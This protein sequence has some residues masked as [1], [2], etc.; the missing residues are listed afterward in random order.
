MYRKIF[1]VFL[2]FYCFASICYA[3]QI[4][5]NYWQAK[6][7]FLTENK[8]KFE[9]EL[10]IGKED[11]SIEQF[12]RWTHFMEARID[13][14]TGE[15]FDAGMFWKEKQNY[16]NQKNNK[17]TRSSNS[18]WQ[19]L[20]PFSPFETNG[21]TRGRLGRINCITMHPTDAN[22]IF[23]GTP[24]GGIW[25]STNQGISWTSNTDRLDNISIA[26]IAIDPTNTNI[27]YAATG[28]GY[29][30][31][32]GGNF[33]GGTYSAGLIKSIDGGA[34]WNTTGLSYNLNNLRTIR[35]ILLYPDN[36][37]VIF[38]STSNGL[39]KSIDAGVT[40]M[41]VLSGSHYSVTFNPQ[42]AQTMYA[43]SGAVRKST[44]GGNTW[45]IITPTTTS[46]ATGDMRNYLAVS[47]QDSNILYYLFGKEDY[48]QLFKSTNGG[49]SW[50]DISADLLA[51][52]Y[53]S[54][55]Y[56]AAVMNIDPN[57]DN[58][59]M[60]GG[61]Y[62]YESKDGGQTFSEV[63]AG[64]LHADH[65]CITYSKSQNEVCYIGC[66]GGLYRK[67]NN[68]L[69]MRSEGLV[70]S[71]IYNVAINPKNPENFYMGLQDNGN[72]A[73]KKGNRIRCT[74]ADGMENIVDSRDTNHTYHEIQYGG[75]YESNDGGLNTNFMNNTAP[76]E[77][78]LPLTQ[79]Y[80]TPFSIYQGVNQGLINL[81]N[82]SKITIGTNNITIL[83]TN[84][85]QPKR[86][87]IS[88]GRRIWTSNSG[89]TGP[90]KEIT[91]TLNSVSLSLL[92]AAVSSNDTVTSYAVFG[93]FNATQKVFKT[94]NNGL[95]WT[96]ITDNLPNVPVNTIC[97]GHDS[98]ETVYIGTDLGVFFR[99]KYMATW[100]PF[101]KNLPNVIITDLR[102]SPSANLLY[103]ASY[104]RG[105]WRSPTQWKSGEAPLKT[106]EI[107]LDKTITIVPNPAKENV[108][109]STAE[110]MT[111]LQI[112]NSLGAVV[113][114][115]QP[116]QNNLTIQTS[117]FVSGMYVVLIKT[118]TGIFRSQLI[119]E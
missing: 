78:I 42:N 92:D 50:I 59:V 24:N 44:D 6:Q 22:T 16:L 87:I 69:T 20:G 105:L 41:Q 60:V 74:G 68:T 86:W 82:G 45:T 61:V 43:I 95:V 113:F 98:L 52:G 57:N 21:T 81:D 109:I 93:G 88:N 108:V 56:Y 65:R 79:D 64:I 40:W 72:K 103:A 73:L 104:G 37:Q 12:N 35:S 106:S 14:A 117:G 36:P 32:G 4:E 51:N 80:V 26:D 67:Q 1:L 48:E 55:G 85:L 23:A 53:A 101:D 94:S 119:V 70:I 46:P 15:C 84:K 8:D 13:N 29:G 7:R 30:Y 110:N 90:W 89:P 112:I 5:Y 63:S 118:K 114:M 77:W 76:Q 38:A 10:T 3:Q 54:Y 71:Q 9:H 115:Q 25:K 111:Q 27:M 11:N 58:N 19:C 66:D 39:Q 28:D 33:W 18:D 97:V 62:M 96:N 102:I 31:D 100:M 17:A 99:D 83:E 34:T 91:T 116:N 2:N 47:H 107:L 49:V 75:L